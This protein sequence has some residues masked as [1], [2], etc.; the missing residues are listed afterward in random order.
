MDAALGNTEGGKTAKRLIKTKR[1]VFKWTGTRKAIFKPSGCEV[2][3]R[4]DGST[5]SKIGRR[6]KRKKR[7]EKTSY[8]PNPYI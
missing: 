7:W 5:A 2:P 1:T 3:G 8:I 6:W 4:Q